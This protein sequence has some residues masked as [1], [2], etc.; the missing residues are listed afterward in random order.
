MCA[1]REPGLARRARL[2]RLLVYFGWAGVAA[3][4]YVLL[5]FT[6]DVK[7]PAVRDSYY[8]T[9][10]S[11]RPDEARVLRQDNL[12]IL[13]IRR[14]AAILRELEESAPGALQDPDSKRSHQ[15]DYARNPWR[16]RVAEYFVAYAIGTDLGC[17]LQVE[18]RRLREVCGEARY[19]FAGR[20][21]MAAG[22]YSNLTIPEYN[23]SN[24][25]NNLTIVP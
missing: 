11:L 17:P 10:P 6:I 5:D 19:D 7:P 9:V 16:S 4:A 3:L 23:F 15:P 24:N 20:A 1:E 12:S 13:V 25:F 14:S 22:S 18:A 21:L 8:F 2:K